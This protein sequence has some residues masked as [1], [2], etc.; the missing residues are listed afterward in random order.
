MTG[1]GSLP[2][3]L[4][5][6]TFTGSAD[7]P[8]A[9]SGLEEAVSPQCHFAVCLFPAQ[10]PVAKTTIAAAAI[11]SALREKPAEDCAFP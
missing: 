3:N 10:K 1:A 5:Q 11:A 9:N 8:K 2:R 7:L 6:N 4:A